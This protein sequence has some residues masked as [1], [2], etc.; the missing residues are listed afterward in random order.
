MRVSSYFKLK[1]SQAALDFIDVDIVKDTPLF[2]SPRAIALLP[3]EWG[4]RCVHLIQNF[5]ETVLLEIKARWP[6][7]RARGH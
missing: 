7:W 2:L 5:F 4:D 6:S 3:S 1:R